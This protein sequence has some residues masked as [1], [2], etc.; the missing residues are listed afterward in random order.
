[1]FYQFVYNVYYRDFTWLLI[2]SVRRNGYKYDLD[3]RTFDPE[4]DEDHYIY[5]EILGGEKELSNE[6]IREIIFDSEGL[7]KYSLAFYLA[8]VFCLLSY[9][10]LVFTDNSILETMIPE[11][12][13]SRSC[14]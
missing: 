3:S 2:K 11:G 7:W 5:G 1:M 9:L 13:I 14:K 6:E 10:R 4:L 8:S 12:S